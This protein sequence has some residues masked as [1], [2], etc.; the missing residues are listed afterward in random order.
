MPG[1]KK[2]QKEIK[3]IMAQF[4]QLEGST[5]VKSSIPLGTA[6]GKLQKVSVEREQQMDHIMS[7]DHTHTHAHTHTHKTPS[8]MVG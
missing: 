7:P 2:K 1:T 8:S 5:I 3:T 4:S 6:S